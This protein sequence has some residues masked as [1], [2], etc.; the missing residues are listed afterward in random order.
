M[1]GGGKPGG[2]LPEADDTGR[3]PVLTGDVHQKATPH[4]PDNL[5]IDDGVRWQYMEEQIEDY[6]EKH[7]EVQKIFFNLFA[8]QMASLK[9]MKVV[10]HSQGDMQ[11]GDLR[12]NTRDTLNVNNFDMLLTPPANPTASPTRS[13]TLGTNNGGNVWG[14]GP[15]PS[16]VVEK[17][18]GR[19]YS[20][21]ELANAVN[22]QSFH[23]HTAEKRRYKGD[24]MRR[25]SDRLSMVLESRWFEPAMGI[26]IL[27]NAANIGWTIDLEL[28]GADTALPRFIENCFLFLFTLEIILR[29]IVRGFTSL[30]DLMNLLDF[31][32]VFVTLLVMVA[33]WL[34]ELVS[35]DG[36]AF[37]SSA[38]GF[39]GVILVLRMLRIL[40]LARAVRLVRSFKSLWRLVQGLIQSGMTMASAF[41][42]MVGTTFLFACFGAEFV[43][44]AYIHDEVIG[45]VIEHYF[46]TVPRILVT[47]FQFITLDGISEFYM[48]LVFRQPLLVIYF[49]LL[50]VIV[51]IALMNLITALLVENAISN[52]RMDEEMVA[53]YT[54]Q[55]LRNLE[56]LFR[57]LFQS[58]DTSGD[59]LINISEIMDAM[60]GGTEI[61]LQLQEIVSHA[62]IIDLFDALDK[63]QSGYVT[64][65]EFIEGLGYMALSDVPLE[66]LQILHIVR[67]CRKDIAKLRRDTRVSLDRAAGRKVSRGTLLSVQSEVTFPD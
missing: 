46:S 28:Q 65:D 63:D 66:T 26:L 61:P 57:E 31:V 43:T 11:G 20:H 56:P 40:R 16:L 21:M 67:N 39:L 23:H 37:Q 13:E 64:E 60:Q 32:L 41:I 25:L 45:E 55:K 9:A 29:L 54:R 53:F 18:K 49:M 52:Q 34:L 30:R 14:Q 44:K 48:P 15:S 36:T 35:S 7:Q 50:L 62:R 4:Q 8:E 33:N 12:D 59:G 47:L 5:P 3:G 27:F 24:F 22:P 58:F 17:P 1:P 19:N 51:S 10:A 6:I 2:A 42:L 38:N